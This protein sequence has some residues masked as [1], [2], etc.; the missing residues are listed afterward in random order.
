MIKT[1][2]RLKGKNTSIDEEQKNKGW[3]GNWSGG[4]TMSMLSLRA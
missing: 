3:D 2:V 1:Q 4:E